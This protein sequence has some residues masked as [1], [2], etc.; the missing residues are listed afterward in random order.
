M[1]QTKGFHPKKRRVKHGSSLKFSCN[2][3]HT[4]I[5]S[6]I[7]M[8]HCI[9][10]KWNASFPSCK[11]MLFTFVKKKIQLLCIRSVY[12]SVGHLK[13]KSW[14]QFS[15]KWCSQQHTIVHKRPSLSECW[16]NAPSFPV[17]DFGTIKHLLHQSW[18]SKK[19]LNYSKNSFG[20]PARAKE[21]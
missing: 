3:S 7:V 8:L 17:N 18:R 14:R 11:G 10:A 16:T 6:S 1:T 12:Y 15:I 2:E 9:D 4:L 13:E 21:G 5:G 20:F 19:A